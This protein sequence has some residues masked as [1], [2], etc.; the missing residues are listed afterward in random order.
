MGGACMGLFGL[1]K[2]GNS[3]IRE[4]PS[5]ESRDVSPA[6]AEQMVGVKQEEGTPYFCNNCGKIFYMK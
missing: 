3:G 4:C 2:K 1:F 6:T 5:C